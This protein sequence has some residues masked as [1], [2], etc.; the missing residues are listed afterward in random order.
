MTCGICK[1]SL[2]KRFFIIEMARNIYWYLAYC[3]NCVGTV[4]VS[5][6]SRRMLEISEEECVAGILI[7]DVHHS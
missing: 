5:D 3:N 4:L 2:A 1:A 6:M 7:S